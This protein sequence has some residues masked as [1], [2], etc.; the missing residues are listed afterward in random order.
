MFASVDFEVQDPFCMG[1][2]QFFHS[3]M[4]EA[5]FTYRG[6]SITSPTS[7]GVEEWWLWSIKEAMPGTCPSATFECHCGGPQLSVLWQSMF[8]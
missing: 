6:F 7:N 2:A 1:F 4:G 5:S 3:S 8:P